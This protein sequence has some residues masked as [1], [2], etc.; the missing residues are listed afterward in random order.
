MNRLRY[1]NHSISRFGLKALF[2][3]CLVLIVQACGEGEKDQPSLFT[4]LAPEQT[5]IDFNNELT[6]SDEF[7]IIEYLY[8]YN[9][10]GV[11]AGDINNDGLVDLYFTANQKPNKLYLNKGNFQFEDITTSA[12]IEESG[13]WSTGATMADVNGDG[14]LDIY[15]C[16]VGDYKEAK[17]RNQ[18][19][20]NNGDGTFAEKAAEY[21]I[22]FVGFST[23]SAFFDYDNDGDLDLYLLNHSIKNPEVFTPV[24][25]RF[26]SFEGGDKLFESQ[27][28]Q[29]G[30]GFKDVTEQSGIYSSTLGFGLGLAVSDVNQ[31]GW[32]DIYISND[33]TEN[34]YL[35]INQQDGT[36]D[37]QLES[38]IQHTSR[39]SMG[40]FAADINNDAEID[41]FT[42]DMLPGDP[43][44]WKKSVGED[45]V[46]VYRIKEQF[47]YGDQYVR[48]TL[49]LNLG[50]GM[51]SDISLFAEN[52]ATDWSW[53][54]LI[55]DMNND[56]LQDIHITNGIYKRPNDLDFVNYMNSN[57]GAMEDNELEQ[58]RI[59]SLPTLK[60]PNYGALNQGK[61]QF[62]TNFEEMQLGFDEPSYSN[63]SAYA[64]LDNDGDLDLV[65]NNLDQEA[66]IYQ[67]NTPKETNYLKVRF[68]GP[69]SN[70]FGI[71]AKVYVES[72]GE[73]LYRENYNSRGFQSSVPPE[74]HFGLGENDQAFTMKV[75]WPG[76]YSQT[77]KN[78]SANQVMML[79]YEEA[80]KSSV[81]IKA[82]NTESVLR[83][84]ETPIDYTHREDEFDDHLREYLLPRKF[85]REGPALAVGDVN[86]DGL[87]DAFLGGA[88]DQ[89]GE[90]WLQQP[91]G[92]MER[93]LL[94]V[95]EQLQRAEDV[96]AQFFDADGDQDLDLYI[97]SGGNEYE[98]GQIFNF[99]RLLINDGQGNFNFSPGALNR[100]GNQG[101][102]LAIADFDGDQDQDVFVGANVVPGAYGQ[103]PKH[104]L[105]M[106]NG[107][108][109]FQDE[110]SNRIASN[111]ALGM[112]NAA[113]PI[114]FDSD[115]D[116][117]LIVAGEWTAPI[118]LENN[119]SGQFKPVETSGMNQDLGWWYSLAVADLNADGLPDIVAGNLGLNSKLKAS[120]EQPV[121]LYWEDIDQNEQIDPIIFHFQNDKETPFFSRDDLIKQVAMFKKLHDDYAS[122]AQNSNPEELLGENYQDFRQKKATEFRSKVYLNQGDGT[123][124][125]VD[126]P[127]SAQ[128]SPARSI[129]VQDFNKD[130][131][132]D[133]LIFGNDYGFRTDFGKADAK[134][135]TLLLGDGKGQFMP[136]SDIALNTPE[137]WGEYRYAKPIIIDGESMILAVRNDDQAIFLKANSDRE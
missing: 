93:K 75:V 16:Q 21:G 51:F 13:T 81:A 17:G 85:S 125:G 65:I 128:W 67:N 14:Y 107:R 5:G 122:Y 23:H 61:G 124:K 22:D 49:Q 1:T 33:F 20:I 62:Q 64:D 41:I 30:K 2:I 4:R 44:I 56:G 116:M 84:Q 108:G 38:R 47:G 114:D 48:N 119:G 113:E 137:T 26:K 76:G 104:Y 35:Y 32:A 9:G 54:P 88:K 105:L 72:D 90:L 82:A 87:E 69:E 73:T 36:F 127:E 52:F 100:V 94:I 25:E 106:N 59:R 132:P 123:F 121:T 28:A 42:T 136:S 3:F 18:L 126:L 97:T 53:S 98:D 115:G 66:F 37:E 50:N 24:N 8:F 7:N 96:N 117:D 68:K 92:S 63:G 40:N 109:M 34:D 46:E 89:P 86:G 60:I 15:L 111:K 55:F 74:L 45:K 129:V 29:G 57:P 39:Y 130:Q 99:D 103:N 135:L 102:A 10:G 77:L 95:L 27:L 83:F 118:L 79:N 58:A 19:F 78:V 11:A 31:D 6:Q 131:I 91:D 120:K 110:F 71:G 112:L 134:P 80:E 101:K 133:L 43:E 70:P 12:G